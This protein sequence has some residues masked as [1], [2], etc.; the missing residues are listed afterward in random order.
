MM[1]IT[2]ADD[3]RTGEFRVDGAE[4]L[5][6][7]EL[8]ELVG[9][10]ASS[11]VAGVPANRAGRRAAAR[12]RQGG[13]DGGTPDGEAGPASL[14]TRSELDAAVAR[15]RASGGKLI[16]PDGLL[17]GLVKDVLEAGL[18]AELT[19][20]L[21][22]GRH[23]AAGRGS[24]NSRNGSTA[25]TVHTEV[26]PVRVDVPR[27]RAGTFEPV[28][29]PRNSTRLGGFEDIVVSLYAGGMTVRDVRHHL[30]RVYGAEIS[31][32]AISTITDSVL[33]EVKAWQTRPLDEVYPVMYIDALI[34]KVRDGGQVR[35]KAAHLAIGIGLD[36]IKHVLGIWI[37]ETEGAKFWLS[38]CTDLRNRGVRDVLVVCCDG[39]TGLPD[40]IETVW[41]RTTV[42]TCTVHLIRT[43]MKFV[44]ARDRQA[45]AAGLRTVYT[46][47]TAADAEAALLAFADTP[48]GRRYPAAV[49]AWT[50]AWE[51]FVPFFAF[52]TEIRKIIY[53]TNAIVTS[54]SATGVLDVQ[55]E[56]LT[57]WDRRRGRGYLLHRPVR[58]R[59][60]G[61]RV[62]AAGVVTCVGSGV[63]DR[64][65]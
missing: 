12:A 15:V 63:V 55:H 38:V 10:V 65:R 62:R 23:E 60:G 51:R 13:S 2:L 50:R 37:T 9:Q 46:A 5:S 32:D 24:G 7:Q 29:L 44:G 26:G 41:P 4:A 53:T 28:L 20:H 18:R 16:G 6:D 54:S 1:T 61:A 31:A 52:P 43:S 22:Y 57:G 56:A 33:E 58:R 64:S 39:L 49:A 48:L 19:E 27:D 25:K 3:A 14:L 36:G 42:Q 45:F 34:V 47:A 40:A 59:C 17:A 35:N 30:R 8:A 11:V 21:G